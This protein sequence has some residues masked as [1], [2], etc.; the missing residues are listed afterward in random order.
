MMFF[1]LSIIGHGMVI[2]GLITMVWSRILE[3]STQ[4]SLYGEYVAWKMVSGQA[5]MMFWIGAPL[6]AVGGLILFMCLAFS[7]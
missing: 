1:I 4:M 6:T 7:S 2:G 5:T 3:H